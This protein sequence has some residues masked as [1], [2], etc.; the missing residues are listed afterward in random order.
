MKNPVSKRTRKFLLIALSICFTVLWSANRTTLAQ[1]K[2]SPGD[3]N[4]LRLE[5]EEKVNISKDT[6]EEVWKYLKKY[7]VDEEENLEILGEGI[8]S[9]FSDEEFTDRYFDTSKLELLKDNSEVRHRKRINNTN[10]DDKKSG[11]ELVQVKV[12]NEDENNLTTRQEVKYDIENNKKNKTV[13]DRHKIIGL[14]END[15]R[16]EFKKK[17]S[18]NGVDPYKLRY[19][20][21]INQRRRRIYLTKDEKPLITISVDEYRTK[22]LWKKV[23]FF[24]VEMELNEIT[25]TEGDETIRQEMEDMRKKIKENITENFTDAT[26]DFTPKYVKTFNALLKAMPFLKFL[27]RIHIL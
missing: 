7:Y 11:R 9:T 15:Q 12:N 19:M 21:T 18:D 13:D 1:E 14:I 22:K 3:F 4:T 25:Y 20:F 27:I 23:E 8:E 6:I 10:T 24:E 26:L 16:E 5:N 17:I 2:P